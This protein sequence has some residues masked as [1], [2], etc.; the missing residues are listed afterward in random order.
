MALREGE[1]VRRDRF[2]PDHGFVEAEALPAVRA[3]GETQACL[4]TLAALAAA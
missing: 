3:P 1:V 4:A 2:E